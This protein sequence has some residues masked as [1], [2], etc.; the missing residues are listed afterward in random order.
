M[1]YNKVLVCILQNQYKHRPGDV[2][3]MEPIEFNSN[4]WS[5]G[6]GPTSYGSG[7]AA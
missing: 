6:G 4:L 2:K 3:P 5:G 7:N 1:G